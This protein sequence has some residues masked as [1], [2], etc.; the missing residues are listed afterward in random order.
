MRSRRRR[1]IWDAL[2]GCGSSMPAQANK[3][4]PTIGGTTG[5]YLVVRRLVHVRH[6]VRR[7]HRVRPPPQVIVEPLV[8]GG[9]ALAEAEAEA[10]TQS[11]PARSTAASL[12]L[13]S[14]RVSCSRRIRCGVLMRCCVPIARGH[15]RHCCTLRGGRRSPCR[16]GR[17]RQ[18]RSTT[19]SRA[20]LGS[21]VH[22]TP[23]WTE[24]VGA[25]PPPTAR[26]RRL[27]RPCCATCSRPSRPAFQASPA[28]VEVGY[29]NRF[30]PV[31][32]RAVRGTRYPPGSRSIATRPIIASIHPRGG[33]V[34][35]FQAGEAKRTTRLELATLSLG[36][37][38]AAMSVRRRSRRNARNQASSIHRL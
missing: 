22:P 14:R 30:L 29:V 9:D 27:R 21:S 20:S 31:S 38:S 11:T 15:Q 34:N 8:P 5:G 37:F 19:T 26:A 2:S 36:S 10:A 25:V 16:R 24:H 4:H 13:R 12:D 6:V 28:P 33:L 18:R 35:G 32:W 1:A 3:R 7:R 23:S 17:E